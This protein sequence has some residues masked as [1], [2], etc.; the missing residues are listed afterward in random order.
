MPR[1]HLRP[2]PGLVGLFWAA[3]VLALVGC[4]GYAGG[5]TVK[6]GGGGGSA[7]PVPSGLSATAGNGQVSLTWSASG[8][9]VGYYVKRSTTS[10]GPYAQVSAQGGV[11]F[12]DTSLTNGT[13]YFYVVSSYNSKAESANSAE[14][15]ATPSA[16]APAAPTGLTAGPGN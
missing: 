10:G 8:G 9:A 3:V 11:T 2:A 16:P 14:V 12:T 4:A 6:G 15:S 13:K 7:P 1:T 5:G